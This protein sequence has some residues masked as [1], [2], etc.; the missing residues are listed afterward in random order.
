MHI[1]SLEMR[2]HAVRAAL[3][4]ETTRSALYMDIT[5]RRSITFVTLDVKSISHIRRERPTHFIATTRSFDILIDSFQ[6]YLYVLDGNT[7][8]LA[9][10]DATT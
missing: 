6:L 5:Q 1:L 4:P 8:R 7:L 2:N 3:A 10:V 9:E